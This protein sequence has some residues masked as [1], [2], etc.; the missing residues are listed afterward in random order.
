MHL[1]SRAAIKNFTNDMTESFYFPKFRSKD[2]PTAL[3][4]AELG[5]C[6]SFLSIHLVTKE[7]HYPDVMGIVLVICSV[8]IVTSS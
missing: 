4:R 6:Q 8:P 2:F 7:E 5:W 3:L 1:I